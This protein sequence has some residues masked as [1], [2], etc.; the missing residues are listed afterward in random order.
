MSRSTPAHYGAQH[1]A[2]CFRLEPEIAADRVPGG[3]G[4]VER[5]RGRSERGEEIALGGKGPEE[6]TRRPGGVHAHGGAQRDIQQGAAEA[7][8]DGLSVVAAR[9]CGGR[10][11]PLRVR[12]VAVTGR[13]RAPAWPAG[14]AGTA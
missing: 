9:G 3:P 1:V 7:A 11:L 14:S 5:S 8:A 2:E 12:V 13:V 6:L 4:V 10:R